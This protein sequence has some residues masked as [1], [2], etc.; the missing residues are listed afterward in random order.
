[1]KKILITFMAMI[2]LGVTVQSTYALERGVTLDPKTVTTSKYATYN[3][4]K[5]FKSTHSARFIP[6]SIGTSCSVQNHTITVSNIANDVSTVLKSKTVEDNGFC[7]KG[8]AYSY[9]KGN[10]RYAYTTLKY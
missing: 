9:Y 3:S 4:K 10:Y 1:M 8:K 2:C 7:A 5:L 6:N